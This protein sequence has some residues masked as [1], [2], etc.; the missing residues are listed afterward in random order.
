[1]AIHAAKGLGP[2]G[3]KIGLQALC[4]DEPFR[5]AIEPEIYE[6]RM[7][8][9]GNYFPVW[10][11][12]RLPLGAVVAV[13][14]LAYCVP[15]VSVVNGSHPGF[16]KPGSSWPLTDQ[17]RAFGDYAPGRYAWLLSDVRRLAT[18]IPWRGA[19]SLWAVPDLLQLGIED[20][21]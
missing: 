4:S 3:G 18:P 19:L 10:D 14:T 7:D 1:V 12:M 11:L 13:A 16:G 2:V 15:T 21:L 20:Q 5:S 17:E 6:E 9:Q 8:G